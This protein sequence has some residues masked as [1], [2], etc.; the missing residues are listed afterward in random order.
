MRPRIVL[1]LLLCLLSIAL[2]AYAGP[3]YTLTDLGPALST[4]ALSDQGRPAGSVSTAGQQVPVVFLPTGAQLLV[5]VGCA[6]G[7]EGQMVAGYAAHGAIRQEAF[8]YTPQQG[9]RFLGTLPGGSASAATAVNL[10]GLVVGYGDTGIPAGAPSIA[11]VA[12]WLGQRWVLLLPHGGNGGATAVSPL[13]RI[14]GDADTGEPHGIAHATLWFLGRVQDLGTLGGKNSGATGVTDTPLVV[15]WSDT[16]T[17]SVGM[18]WTPRD[19]MQA[20][21]VLNTAYPFCRASAVQTAA[22]IVGQCAP[23]G[24]GSSLA[25]VWRDRQVADLNTLVTAPTW[26]LQQATGVNRQ[27]QIAGMG[28]V[29]TQSRAYLLT[30]VPTTVAR[31]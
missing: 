20:L 10:W 28:R 8:L 23:L 26:S 13:G 25:T 21:P 31:R 17:G 2:T 3:S 5:V 9:L 16:L 4:G 1:S 7:S 19:G 24:M 22:L 6:D 12:W 14:V 29:G 15:G 11:P 27:G 30:P 18:T